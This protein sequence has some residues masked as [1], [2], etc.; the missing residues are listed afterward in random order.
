M[1]LESKTIFTYGTLKS[2]LYKYVLYVNKNHEDVDYFTSQFVF[3]DLAKQ[4]FV[5]CTWTL[6]QPLCWTWISVPEIMLKCLFMGTLQY[7]KLLNIYILL[8]FHLFKNWNKQK[9][10]LEDMLFFITDW[11]KQGSHAPQEERAEKS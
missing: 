3:T 4:F 7:I 6:R 11:E 10:L 2:C 8:T 5:G 1:T 9:L